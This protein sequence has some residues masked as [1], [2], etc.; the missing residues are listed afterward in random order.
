[1]SNHGT[2]HPPRNAVRRLFSAALAASI[3]LLCG[4]CV[5]RVMHISSDPDGALVYL[6]DEEVGKTPLDVE[7]TFYGTYDVRLEKE[8][9][10]ALWVKQKAVAPWWETIGPD[11]AGE[12]IP[13]N[14]V[15]LNWHFKMEP[16]GL[17]DEGEV[18]E[19]A[20]QMR[21]VISPKG[22][23]GGAPMTPTTRPGK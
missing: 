2:S 9:F 13:N 19:R 1:M 21:A 3:A 4:G 18:I 7:F 10:Q 12:A 23:P 15:E 5:E 6:N 11:L 16:R 14:K 8:G 17:D 20:R 22:S